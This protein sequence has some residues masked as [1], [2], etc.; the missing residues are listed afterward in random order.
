MLLWTLGIAAGSYF[1]VFS[2]A[3]LFQEKLIFF[4]DKL[5][6]HYRFS[7]STAWKEWQLKTTDGI[8]LH[9]LLFSAAAKPKGLIFY[10]HGNAGSCDSWGTIAGLYAN[11]NYDLFILDYRGFGKSEGTIYSEEQFYTDVQSAYDELKP[12]Y[13]EKNI[14]IIGFS[15]G[16]GAA[17]MLASKN[18]PKLLIL[19]APYYS[20]TDLTRRL[21]PFLPAIALK[22][23]FRT[24]QF[25]PQILA[26][27]VLFH[28]DRDEVV[29]YGS[30]LKLKPLLK[31]ADKLI[32]LKGQ[33]HN[34][35]NEN[36]E[37]INALRA[38]L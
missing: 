3:Y 14:V 7:F 20:L 18:H 10:L 33:L 5:P 25:I 9:G 8:I 32:T 36:P 38:L 27:V 34:G 31:P 37:Y 6:Q 24:Y 1:L 11:L 21:Y 13:E 30:S 29:Y 26:P 15:I 35:L 2:L 19:Q 4:P 12:S 22:Y 16:T 23:K 17:A 28:G